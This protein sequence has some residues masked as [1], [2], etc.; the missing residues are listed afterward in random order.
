M[1]QLTATDTTAN[2][3]IDGCVL[4]QPTDQVQ[5]QLEKHHK[6]QDETLSIL[7]RNRIFIPHFILP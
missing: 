2:I 5:K 1:S 4:S 7:S 3:T 6:Q